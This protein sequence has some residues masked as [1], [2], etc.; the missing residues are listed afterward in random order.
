MQPLVGQGTLNDAVG[1]H[2]PVSFAA[3][4][5]HVH[6]LA[7]DTQRKKMTAARSG[8]FPLLPIVQAHSSPDPF[9]QF[10]NLI[11]GVA[12]AE[13]VEPAGDVA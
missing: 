3:S 9:G 7:R 12:D 6:L 10:H 4:R 11:V 5:R 8:L 1:T 13:V 2:S